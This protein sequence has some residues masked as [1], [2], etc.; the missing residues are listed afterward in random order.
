MKGA[1][2]DFSDEYIFFLPPEINCVISRRKRKSAR[3][4]HPFHF[5]PT[6]LTLSGK[7]DHYTQDCPRAVI[8]VVMLNGGLILGNKSGLK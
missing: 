1:Q 6:N 4:F 7:G 5:Y 8:M 2:V 3:K